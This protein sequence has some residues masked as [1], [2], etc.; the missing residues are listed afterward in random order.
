MA[1]ASWSERSA[2]NYQRVKDGEHTI[3]RAGR[4]GKTPS[5]HRCVPRSSFRGF[6][7]R[8]FLSRRRPKPDQRDGV[9]TRRTISRRG[10]QVP[11]APARLGTR[12]ASDH[13]RSLRS[14]PPNSQGDPRSLRSPLVHSGS[15]AETHRFSSSPHHPRSRFGLRPHRGATSG[16]TPLNEAAGY[17]FSNLK[18]EFLGNSVSMHLAFHHDLRSHRRTLSAS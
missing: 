7:D 17:N 13:G 6:H 11:R 8:F 2:K 4:G 1:R 10:G 9:P 16:R 12:Q 14:P 3:R 15:L 18:S 5:N